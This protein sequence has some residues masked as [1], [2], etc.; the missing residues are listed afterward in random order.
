MELVRILII[1][2]VIKF[3]LLVSYSWNDQAIYM[4]FTKKMIILSQL[5]LK[6]AFFCNFFLFI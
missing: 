3:I 4:Q 6:Q 1:L 2:F 5:F